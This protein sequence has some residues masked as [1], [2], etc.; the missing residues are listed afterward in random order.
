MAKTYYPWDSL[1][2]IGDSF[3]INNTRGIKHVRQLVYARHQK[4]KDQGLK[5]RHET[6]INSEGEKVLRVVRVA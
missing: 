2:N 3:E 4:M 6:I 1:T 5:Y